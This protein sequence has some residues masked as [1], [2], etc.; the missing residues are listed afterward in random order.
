MNKKNPLKLDQIKAFLLK[1][2]LTVIK[3]KKI[4]FYDSI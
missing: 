4:I 3:K 2:G 1:K